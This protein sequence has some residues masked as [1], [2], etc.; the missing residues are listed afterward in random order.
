MYFGATAFFMESASAVIIRWI[1]RQCLHVVG[2]PHPKST[3][4]TPQT[5]KTFDDSDPRD[6]PVCKVVDFSQRTE[7]NI[8]HAPVRVSSRRFTWADRRTT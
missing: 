8:T 2:N 4:F 1:I 7:E 3:K 5:K 6:S